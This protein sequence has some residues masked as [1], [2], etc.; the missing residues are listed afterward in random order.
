VGKTTLIK[1][2]LGQLQPDSGSVKVGTNLEVAYF[3][4]LRDKLDLNKT[5][6]EFI[7]EGREQITINDRSRHVISYLSDFLFTPARAR[8]P[9]SSLSG[10]EKAR[11]LLA[12]L[13]SK[14]VNMLVMDEPTNDLDIETLELLEE[15]LLDFPGTLLLVSHDR[16]FMD[17][18]ITGTLA[19][20]GNGVVS[21]YVG[22][23]SDW[24]KHAAT[25]QADVQP[26]KAA[27]SAAGKPHKAP[28]T[29]KLSYQLQ[30]ELAA[31]PGKIEKL[32][33]QQT[34]LTERL[35]DST[36]YSRD[37]QLAEQI[38]RELKQL[39]DELDLCYAR[40]DELDS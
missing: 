6:V 34:E 12:Y 18:V 13:F 32:E 2:L 31:L 23:Y 10:G 35:S 16:Q 36:L 8:S 21:E 19:F 38:S 20:E 9:I 1:I 5:I 28:A 4:Q 15:L 37:P 40:W 39:S 25:R 24:A 7:G 33:T 22:G 17:N 11:V 26:E 14:P 29:K 30:R 3:D 27:K